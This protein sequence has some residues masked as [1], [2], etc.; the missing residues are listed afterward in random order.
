MQLKLKALLALAYLVFALSIASISFNASGEG[1]V[2]VYEEDL[3]VVN[4]SYT[5]EGVYYKQDGN[6]SVENGT[7]IIRNATFELLQDSEHKYYFKANNSNFILEHAT[8]TVA[9]KQLMPYLKLNFTIKNTN[10][11][12]KQSVISFPGRMNMTDSRVEIIDSTITRVKSLPSGIDIDENDDAPIVSC[13]QSNISIKSSTLEEYTQFYFNSCNAF[14]A[15]SKFK[16]LHETHE[17]VQNFISFGKY[18]KELEVA[19]D[20]YSLVANPGESY[21]VGNF[22]PLKYVGYTRILG[23]ELR[24]G[25]LG[26]F[27]YSAGDCLQYSLDSGRTYKNT[28]ITFTKGFTNQ[29][30]NLWLEGVRSLEDLSEIKLLFCNTAPKNASN[31]KIA[32]DYVQIVVIYD[33][34]I[35]LENT[36]FYAV[37]SYFDI[38][39]RLGDSSP[40][41]GMQLLNSS[42]YL[43][44]YDQH[45]NRLKAINQSFVWLCNVTVDLTETG[46]GIPSKG[47]P[48][49]VGD[50]S[51]QISISRWLKITAT[52]KV[53]VPLANASIEILFVLNNTSASLPPEIILDWMGKNITNWNLT[54][55]DGL[56]LIPL[57]SD[58][59]TPGAW[60]NSEFVGNYA[61]I[62]SYVNLTAFTTVSLAQFPNLTENSNTEEVKIQ[63]SELLLPPTSIA[64]EALIISNTY[65]N[66]GDRITISGTVKYSNNLPVA[67]AQVTVSIHDRTVSTFTLQDGSYSIELTAPS[68]AQT[69]ILQ[70]TVYETLYGLSP[71]TESRGLIVVAPYSPPNILLPIVIMVVVVA[72]FTTLLLRNRL[73][74]WFYVAKARMKREKFIE[75][76]E[77]SYLIPISA[78]R[79]P[80]CKASFEEEVAKCSECG[81]II[82][83]TAERCPA[84]GASFEEAR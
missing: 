27:N 39:F 11:T 42:N 21:E 65:C 15:D 40:E 6:V 73:K 1:E 22:Q 37:N 53:A 62:G 36:N 77:C 72:C 2:V 51:S 48:P 9:T 30:F 61:I 63:F 23:V 31:S 78:K 82:P 74:L 24:A 57:Q 29:S 59:L 13:L 55:S 44:N 20:D 12:V 28:T 43:F 64:I 25:T 79:C 69:Y 58:S 18:K 75:C 50:V 3:I 80:R 81:A 49:F 38:D 56:L 70:I 54:N 52:D 35:L 5:I 68:A 33:T 32:V 4:S 17:N 8:L 46:D 67:N 34:D 26:D 10:F 16:N 45:H 83:I 66:P 14:I 47:N 84:C 41:E 19:F 7:L 76:S 71:C 60:P